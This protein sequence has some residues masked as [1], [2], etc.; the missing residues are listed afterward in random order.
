[1]L[2]IAGT[3]GGIRAMGFEAIDEHTLWTGAEANS[4]GFGFFPNAIV[5]ASGI[6]ASPPVAGL[7]SINA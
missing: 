5:L 6:P 4:Y 3:L 1:M 7:C 2:P